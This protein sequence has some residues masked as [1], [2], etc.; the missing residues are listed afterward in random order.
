MCKDTNIFSEIASF[1]QKSSKIS[2]IGAIS[3]VMK[4]VGAPTSST[5]SY[6]ASPSLT[7]RLERCTLGWQ[8]WPFH[9]LGKN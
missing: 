6:L 9:L 4:N 5:T 1:F 3:D 2:A 7:F 8:S